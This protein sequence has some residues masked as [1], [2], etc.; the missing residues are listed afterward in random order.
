MVQLYIFR[1]I[2]TFRNKAIDKR[3]VYPVCVN[4]VPKERYVALSFNVFT[5]LLYIR[6][7][8][9]DNLFKALYHSRQEGLVEI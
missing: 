2:K 4:G 1:A 3:R 5:V 6:W 9:I 7:I 8:V